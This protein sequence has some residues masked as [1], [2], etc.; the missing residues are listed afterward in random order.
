MSGAAT[1]T[2]NKLQLGA[3]L[4][5]FRVEAGLSQEQL[6]AQVFPRASARTAQSKVAAIEGGDRSLHES[7]LARMQA[8]LDITDAPMIELMERMHRNSSQRGR[9]GGYRAAYGENF[10]KY[11]DLEE[12]A[13]RMR[14]VGVCVI[15]DM[16]QSEPYVRELLNDDDVSDEVREAQIKARIAR[17]QLIRRAGEDRLFH[18]VL[19]ESTLRKRFGSGRLVMREQIAHML[20]LSRMPGITIQVV[21]F[22]QSSATAAKA[23]LHPFASLRIPTQG[24]A[25]SLEYVY[26]STPGDRR[27][28]DDKDSVEVYDRLFT[29]AVAA[30]LEGD[31]ARRFMEEVSREHR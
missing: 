6:G 16:L 26:L 8:V 30:G 17:T 13:D 10:R 5:K 24:I 12:D 29:R 3:L 9:W 25:S 1:P 21:P 28:L 7:E 11:I 27:Y 2:V 4:K 15:P 14:E 18:F 22:P 19:C 20:A 31:H 23:V